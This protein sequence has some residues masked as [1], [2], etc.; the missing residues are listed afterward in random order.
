MEKFVRGLVKSVFIAC[1]VA[2]MLASIRHVA[3]FF[4]DFEPNN[5]ATVGSYMLAGAFDITAL[6]TTIGVMFFRKSMPGWVFVVVWI[7]IAGIAGYS[8]VINLEY[9]SHYQSMTLLMQPTGQTTPILDAH[10]NVHYVPVMQINTSLEFLNPFLAS[11]FTIF[12]LVYSVIAEFF[13]TK[14]VTAAE[15][16]ARKAYLT[17]TNGLLEEIQKLEA[18]NKKPG[19]I[20]RAKETAKEVVE[21]S[22][23]V[24]ST[25]KKQEQI[26]EKI[27]Q[28]TTLS[29][30]DKLDKTIAFIR[31]NPQA[32]DEE[33][34]DHLGMKR[35]ASARFWRLK[36]GEIL[37]LYPE[38]ASISQQGNDNLS[39]TQDDEEIEVEAAFIDEENGTQEDEEHELNA[40]NEDTQTADQRPI[41]FEV[42]RVL[43]LYPIVASWLSTK[44]LTASVEEI[45]KATG[46]RKSTVD[47]AIKNK[48]L[49]RSKNPELI[50]VSSVVKWLK[51]TPVR[52]K[53]NGSK[54]PTTG[55][56]EAINLQSQLS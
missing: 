34:A 47:D 9:T 33:L 43:T 23:E 53:S 52:Q 19:F 18:K 41:D 37:R 17:E 42:M 30:E 27:D 5:D 26:E 14:P 35:A 55:E 40:P 10:G 51:M 3:T 22:K 49:I 12:S 25:A 15:L 48:Q 11:G 16:E 13:G 38:K 32:T 1:Y 36:A 6:V 8:Y 29:E 20:Q 54:D 7:F 2:F 21:A 24:A 45:V 4:N 28:I 44:K 39:E 56:L 50:R 46:K 31:E